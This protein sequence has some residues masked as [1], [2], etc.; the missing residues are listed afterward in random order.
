MAEPTSDPILGE[1]PRTEEKPRVLKYIRFDA[2]GA[3]AHLTLARPKQNIMNIDML[4]E[5]TWAIESL[6]VRDDIRL[7]LLDSAPECEGYFSAAWAR[8][9]TEAIWFSR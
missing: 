1:E 7:I 4:K 3:A 6:T 2:S 5:M 9:A 8:K